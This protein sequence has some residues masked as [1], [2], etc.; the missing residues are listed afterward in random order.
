MLR[1]FLIIVVFGAALYACSDSSDKYSISVESDTLSVDSTIVSASSIDNVIHPYQKELSK[2]MDIVIAYAPT[3]QVKGRPN[4]A[5]NNWA[6][7]AILEVEKKKNGARIQ[8]N[9]PV[10]CLLN[11]GGLRSSIN[12]GDVTVG[13]IYKFMP[14]DNRVIWAEMPV[15]LLPEM[16][17]YLKSSGGEPIAGAKL[18]GNNLV[19]DT[20]IGEATSFWVITSDYLVNG[21]DHM[22]FFKKRIRHEYGSGL[23]RDVFIEAAKMQDTLNFDTSERIKI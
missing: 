13:D 4:A 7:D 11:V 8:K 14:F 5:L 6:A 23:M 22:D 10:M 16:A 21:G 20:K 18:V 9:L 15:S 3:G 17:A 2:N 1:N 12:E 19:L